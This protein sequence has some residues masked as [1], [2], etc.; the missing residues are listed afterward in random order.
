MF[1]PMIG[2]ANMVADKRL[3]ILAVGTSKPMPEFPGVPTMDESGYADFE[4][5]APW[6]GLLAPAG[7]PEAIV[8]KLNMAMNVALKQPEV[9]KRMKDLGATPSGASP[10]EFKAFL[11]QDLDRWAKVV[12]AAG[13]QAD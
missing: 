13:I 10:A 8:N 2:I 4:Q 11:V 12:Q 9:I 5:T 6:V 3:K 7:T 1:Y